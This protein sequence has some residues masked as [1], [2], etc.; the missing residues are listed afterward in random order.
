MNRPTPDPA[1]RWCTPSEH[2][3]AGK[4]FIVDLIV[5]RGFVAK[6]SDGTIRP[7]WSLDDPGIQA[8]MQRWGDLRSEPTLPQGDKQSP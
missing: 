5:N 4:P 8:A 6:M 3:N 2:K 1:C 7:D